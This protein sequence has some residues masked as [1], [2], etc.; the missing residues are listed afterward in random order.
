MVAR[1]R[2]LIEAVPEIEW[3]QGARAGVRLPRLRG[4]RAARDGGGRGVAGDDP[5]RAADGDAAGELLAL[6]WEDVDLVAGRIIVR[7]A[8]DAGSR[9]HAEVGQVARDP[10]RRD[11]ARPRSRRTASARTARVLRRR[12]RM[13]TEGRVQASA[14]ARVQA[15]GAAA[16]RVARAAA[17]VRLAP[18]DARGAAQGGPGAAGPRDDRDD[19][20]LRASGAACRAR[21]R[22]LLDRRRASLGNE[23][24]T[25]AENESK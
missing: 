15:G 25:A 16:D 23:W 22:A 11:G 6:R 9:R 5:R 1:K 17:H 18:R 3:L 8:V 20:A 10:A 4:G 14:L 2:G 19:D 12:G 13:L 7:R 24:A 21:R